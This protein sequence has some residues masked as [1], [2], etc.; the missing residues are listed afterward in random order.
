M[1]E[2]LNKEIYCDWDDEVKFI[3]CK[4]P[5]IKKTYHRFDIK[6]FSKV[7][8]VFSDIFNILKKCEMQ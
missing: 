6:G 7:F 1:K 5:F 2:N 8:T 4:G 3:Y